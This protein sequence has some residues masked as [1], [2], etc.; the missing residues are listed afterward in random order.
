MSFTA[1]ATP[2]DWAKYSDIRTLKDLCSDSG[3]AA[4]DLASNAI[5]LE[6]LKAASGDVLAACLV[7]HLY[8]PEDLDLIAAT[9]GHSQSLLKQL[10]CK[11]ATIAAI[12]R[13]PDRIGAES[14][15]V[16]LEET[17]DYLD[18]L[19]SGKR[20]FVVPGST[21]QPDAGTVEVDGPTL[22]TMERVN[23]ISIRTRNYYPSVA[24]RLP[25]GRA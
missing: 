25:R 16:L 11:I 18:R 3:T 15:K 23:G 14:L 7:S 2:A 9:D 6:L 17:E 1:Y 19:R 5:A 21:S 10:V 4:S 8:E 22:A 20:L 12:R 24:Q 13:R